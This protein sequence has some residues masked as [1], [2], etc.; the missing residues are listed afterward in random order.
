[1]LLSLL[2][3][4]TFSARPALPSDANTVPFFQTGGVFAYFRNIPDN[5]VTRDKWVG[6]NSIIV[7]D[8]MDI[9]I[10]KTT[11]CDRNADIVLTK[12]R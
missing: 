1:V 3:P 10:T 6:D 4:L 7:V 8:A 2:A 12:L 9:R 11:V 5:L